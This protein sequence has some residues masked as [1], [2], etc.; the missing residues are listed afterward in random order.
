M[1]EPTDGERRVV[2]TSALGKEVAKEEASA[3]VTLFI[4]EGEREEAALIPHISVRTPAACR[5]GWTTARLR[6]PFPKS[7]T[8]GSSVGAFKLGVSQDRCR[9]HYSSIR[10]MVFYFSN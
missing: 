4:G 7:L 9:M 2:L 6:A 10:P 5:T 3:G 8:G 1:A